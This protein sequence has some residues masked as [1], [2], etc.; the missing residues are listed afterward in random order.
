MGRAHA[1]ALSSRGAKVIV[2][3]IDAKECALV[4]EEIKSKGS[5]AE[6]FKMDVSSKKED[7]EEALKLLPKLD[8]AAFTEK[9][10]PLEEFAEAWRLQKTGKHLKIILK[11]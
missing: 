2:T 11:P 10:M 4:V 8:T 5:E 6:C 7:F 1:L 9:V 3:D